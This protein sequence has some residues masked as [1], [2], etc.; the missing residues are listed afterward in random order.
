MHGFFKKCIDIFFPVREDA[1]IVSALSEEDMHNLYTVHTYAQVIVL[2]TFADTRIR[3]LIHEAKFHENTHAMYM[4]G[5][6]FNRHITESEKLIDCILPIPLSKIRMK[7]RGHNQVLSV[8]KH[9]RVSIPI[10]TKA[11]TRVRD[12]KPQ[13][14]L[15][16]SERIQNIQGA[17]VVTNPE[18]ITQKH[19]LL[20]DDVVTTGSTLGAARNELLKHHPASVTCIAFAH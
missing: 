2:S 1:R 4:L 6:L 8:L 3:A 10:E 17:F 15:N 12:T 5:I 7:K 14:N 11:L 9:A 18:A 16:K 20:I 19:I 13:A